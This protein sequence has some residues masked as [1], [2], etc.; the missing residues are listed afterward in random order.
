[1]PC[2]AYR[3]APS[4]RKTAW[5]KAAS[6]QHFACHPTF[7]AAAM[8]TCSWSARAAQRR[9]P[10]DQLLLTAAWRTRGTPSFFAQATKQ[11]APRP[12]P[13]QPLLP[14]I[15]TSGPFR[16]C[17]ASRSARWAPHRRDRMVPLACRTWLG[18]CVGGL[19]WVKNGRSLLMH[20]V[21]CGA[22]GRACGACARASA[23]RSRLRTRA[24]GARERAG[25][26][27]VRRWR[28]VK[29]GPPLLIQKAQPDV[30]GPA[31]QDTHRGM[32][33]LSSVAS[34][35]CIAQDAAARDLAA[36]SWLSARYVCIS[37]Y[38]DAT[39]CL[40]RYG[41]LQD[42]LEPV[43]RYLVKDVD[44]AGR[45]H[46]KTV[47]HAEYRARA[48]RSQ[49]RSGVLEVLAQSACVSYGS[50][51]ATSMQ[52]F[53]LPPRLLQNGKAS[54]IATAVE[55]AA[56]SLSVESLKSMADRSPEQVVLMEEVVDRSR[57]NQRK[58]A[59]TA[60][61][62]RE[63]PRIFYHTGIGCVVHNL[64][65]MLSDS[66][67]EQATIG[68]VHAVQFVMSIAGR[69]AA[70]QQALRELIASELVIM[71]GPPPDE[72]RAHSAQV[73]SHTLL[74]ALEHTRGSV[75]DGWDIRRTKR[76][77][78]R[79]LA[80][81]RLLNMLNGDIRH[82]VVVHYEDAA[83]RGMGGPEWYSDGGGGRVAPHAIPAEPPP[84]AIE[85]MAPGPRSRLR[86]QSR[87]QKSGMSSKSQP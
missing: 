33:A 76:H 15:R 31:V 26:R 50:D 81:D 24:G 4:A 21:P 38:H 1:M 16:A 61:Q 39:P 75:D 54:T 18:S 60:E 78:S 32:E 48:P 20:L 17:C 25:G 6:G 69:R 52:R 71:Q 34:I 40:L 62:L 63:H 73:V 70:L 67:D 10:R 59:F 65:R 87:G 84:D 82:D 57:A 49:M 66:I 43:A 37:R 68:N 3:P 55:T 35:W 12:P 28:A 9:Q 80:Q 72:Y 13:M 19:L 45:V 51:G 58:L 86:G 8:H 83:S 64:N 47:A 77:K 36:S 14:R 2:S 23:V 22:G 27:R 7:G 53:T 11:R 29:T 30:P 41:R 5:R 42:S 44:G 85:R 74:R 79:L 56:P 46:W